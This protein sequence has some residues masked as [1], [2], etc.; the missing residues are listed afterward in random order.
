MENQNKG[1]SCWNFLKNE[2]LDKVNMYIYNLN[3]STKHWK[4]TSFISEHVNQYNKFPSKQAFLL[5]KFYIVYL[6]GAL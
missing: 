2:T 1:W 6:F 5:C 4:F 3:S